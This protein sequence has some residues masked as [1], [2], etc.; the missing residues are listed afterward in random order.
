MLQFWSVYY[1]CQVCKLY[2]YFGQVQNFGQYLYFSVF[3][4]QWKCPTFSF[5]YIYVVCIV[6][7]VVF[8]CTFWRLKTLVLWRKIARNLL[9]FVHLFCPKSSTINCRKT[10]ITQEG[11]VIRRKLRDSLLNRILMIYRFVYTICCHFNKI[12][13]AWSVYFHKN[14]LLINLFP[15]DSCSCPLFNADLFLY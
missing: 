9:I 7:K 14:F 10:S 5:C 12:V 8:F 4:K 11:L 6:L 13:L 2:F 3:S 1:I 15:R